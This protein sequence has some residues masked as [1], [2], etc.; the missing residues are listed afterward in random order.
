GVPARSAAR[1][2]SRRDR[3]PVLRAVKARVAVVCVLVSAWLLAATP[4]LVAVAQ[5][6]G[7]DESGAPLDWPALAIDRLPVLENARTGRWPLVLWRAPDVRELDEPA[8]RRMLE[9]GIAPTVK[10][11]ADFAEAARRI[12]AAG[13]PVIALEAAGGDWPYEVD[14]EG[15]TDG[16]I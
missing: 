13:G 1:V 4:C 2:F 9:R 5:P 8:I 12:Q 15:S 7:D 6:S 14:G 11:Q 10:L 3:S 16:G